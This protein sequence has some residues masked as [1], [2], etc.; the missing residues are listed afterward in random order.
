MGMYLESE[1]NTHQ[2]RRIQGALLSLQNYQ[3]RLRLG[4][5][6]LETKA[7]PSLKGKNNISLEVV[8]G[9]RYEALNDNGRQM[10]RAISIFPPKPNTFSEDAAS[11]VAATSGKIFRDQ[12]VD[13]GL[14]EDVGGDRYTLHQTIR[15]FAFSMLDK[16]AGE[17][18]VAN[19]RLA[20]F[21]AEYVKKRGVQ[22]VDE[23]NINHALKWASDHEQN[24]LYLAL[25]SGMQ[26]FWRDYWRVTE[27]MEHLSKGFSTAKTMLQ[28]T[29]DP[30]HLQSMME[31]ACNYGS[32]LL[33][34]NRLDETK[35]VFEAILEIAR[36]ETSDRLSEGIALFNL[37]VVALQ[38]GD[39]EEAR[40]K[41]GE[42]LPIRF[43]EQYQDEWALDFV[44]FCRIAQS[45]T[46]LEILKDYFERAIEIDRAVTNRRGEGVDLFSLGNIALL[47]KKYEVAASKYQECLVVTEEFEEKIKEGVVP[48][49]WSET[50]LLA[51]GIVL[52]V[53]CEIFLFL[54]NFGLA[55]DYLQQSM[56]IIQELQH[57]REFAVNLLYSGRLALA[58]GR[59]EDANRFFEA[60]LQAA[61]EVQ[62]Q[63]HIADVLFYLGILAELEGN[64]YIAE[65]FLRT[66]LELNKETQN[67]PYIA[68]VRLRLGYLLLNQG[69]NREEACSMIA[70]AI[71]WYSD[72]GLT[73]DEVAKLVNCV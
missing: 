46:Q 3:K 69:R 10:L 32:A 72:M 15:D 66:S 42:S 47:Q 51:K 22:S 68:N 29:K 64:L 18:Q 50:I 33:V 28:E 7:F 23:A 63:A 41:F 20:H 43:E 70:D 5:V 4:R 27:S 9:V 38:R 12:L 25:A 45:R 1:A 35:R 13:A 37:G 59:K 2:P 56:R 34:A 17:N 40:V 19:E 67:A 30:Q 60:A 24:E 6:T 31:V 26:Y 71:H 73:D 36:G 65:E 16:Q 58:S 48:A 11:E 21:F 61:Q 57:R 54:E 14:V 62:D 49:R 53:L 44:T 55:E 39:L 52:S 8:I